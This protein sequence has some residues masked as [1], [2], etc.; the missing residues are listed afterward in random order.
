M[1]A[2]RVTGLGSVPSPCAAPDLHD[3]WMRNERQRYKYYLMKGLFQDGF[4]RHLTTYSASLT[5][6]TISCPPTDITT[7]LNHPLLPVASTPQP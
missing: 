6:H 5:A 3:V 7:C 1:Y 4:I 2:D